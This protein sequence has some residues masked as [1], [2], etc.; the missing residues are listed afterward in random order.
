MRE[1]LMHFPMVTPST[2]RIIAGFIVGLLIFIALRVQ[3]M[4]LEVSWLR[5]YVIRLLT[6]E[7]KN[8]EVT[9]DAHVHTETMHGDEAEV[10]PGDVLHVLSEMKAPLN[11]GEE[12][13]E[14]ITPANEIEDDDI[15]CEESGDEDS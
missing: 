2:M 10:F 7:A 14:D 8:N 1:N 3:I 12:R 11:D 4:Q 5:R 9:K 6:K 15:E 13:V